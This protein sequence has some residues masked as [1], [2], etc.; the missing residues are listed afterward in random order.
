MC[1]RILATKSNTTDFT[2]D[3]V[4]LLYANAQVDKLVTIIVKYH[5]LVVSIR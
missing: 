4:V 5:S 3:N 2:F 1:S